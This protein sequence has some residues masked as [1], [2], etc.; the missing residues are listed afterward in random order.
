MS[1]DEVDETVPAQDKS[2]EPVATESAGAEPETTEPGEPGTAEAE[3]KPAESRLPHQ[4]VLGAAAFAIAAFLAAAVFGI[5]WWIAA[6]D[7]NADRAAAREDVVRVGSAAVRDFTELDYTKPDQYFD[8][9]I[10]ASTKE[11]GD[12]I[13]AGRDANK[14]TM[15]EAKT[16]TTTK[17]LDI[18]VDELNTDEGKAR[19]LA[20]VQVEVKQ[21]DKSAVKPMRVEVQM[22]R[23]DQNGEQVWK[24]SGIDPVPV[25]SSGQ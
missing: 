7:D 12:Q 5:L 13:A 17:V 6:G 10:A 9:A 15:V 19:F 16:V 14:K 2:A 21:G 24:L 22:T 25:V 18:A 3:S 1:S 11:V 23:Q 20:A 4:L 8:R